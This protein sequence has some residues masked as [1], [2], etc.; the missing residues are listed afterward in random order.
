MQKEV[1]DRFSS[2]F[3]EF[4]AHPPSFVAI[5]ACACRLFCRQDIVLKGERI[6]ML[7]DLNKKDKI[8]A[9]ERY[10]YA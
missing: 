4:Q 7:Q 10:R 1:G 6:A 8:K 3:H 2:I 9:R 5:S